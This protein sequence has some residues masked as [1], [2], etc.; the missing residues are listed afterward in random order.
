M[1]DM[2]IGSIAS[3]PLSAQWGSINQKASSNR[4]VGRWD[5]ALFRSL[6]GQTIRN[7]PTFRTNTGEYYTVVLTDT[8]AIL[9]TTGT[10]ET[11]RYITQTYRAGH[12][13]TNDGT[14]IDGNTVVTGDSTDWD[15]SGLAPGDYFILEEDLDGGEDKENPANP[16]IKILSIDGASQLTL[17]GVYQGTISGAMTA[18]Y[19][20]RLV[21]D[22]PE[23]E[24]W[25]Y[26]PVFGTLCFSHGNC[27]VQQFN[28]TTGYAV[29]LNAS[30]AKNARYLSVFSDRLIMADMVI[31]SNRAPWTL[32]WSAIGDPTDW[33]SSS[34]GVKTFLDTD[35]PITGISSAGGMFFVYKK[36]MYHIGKE[37][38]D[39]T[40]PIQFIQ[41]QRGVSNWAPYSLISFGG[42]NAF[43]G[44]SDF[45][46]INGD[47]P[48]PIGGPIRRKFFSIISDT[49]K[50]RVFGGHNPRYN[51]LLWVATTTEGQVVLSFDY[52]EKAWSVYQFESEITG[53]GEMAY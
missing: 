34:A 39:Y 21:Y 28:P 32:M 22:L 3:N 27:L 20:T 19:R 25:C 38:Q 18:D 47:T 8:D 4:V 1:L 51:E 36:M 26:A 6:S 2:S 7:V 44:L 37:T 48:E 16:W 53:L 45:Y 52:K 12:I 50:K 31:D 17:D 13:L 9:I 10:D 46:V 24:K 30:Y 33:T 11:F 23:G 43:M 35:D 41:D 49:E 40:A 15:S 5:H 29:P 42:T 14:D